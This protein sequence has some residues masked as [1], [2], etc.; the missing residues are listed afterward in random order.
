MLASRRSRSIFA[1]IAPVS[2][3]TRRV[4]KLAAQPLPNVKRLTRLPCSCPGSTVATSDARQ[5]YRDTL[6]MIPRR[7]EH[8]ITGSTCVAKAGLTAAM[9]VFSKALSEREAV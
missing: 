8:A 9:K 3:A 4:K 7:R 6:Y 2:P 1:R 5:P